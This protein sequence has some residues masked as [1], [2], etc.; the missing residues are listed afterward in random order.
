MKRKVLF[1]ALSSCLL[2]S[3]VLAKDWWEKKPYMQWSRKEVK[4]MLDNS[5]W[6]KIHT[7]TIMNRM[8]SGERTFQSLGS[9]DLER[10]KH[11]HFHIYFLTAKPVRMAIAQG[12]SLDSKRAL[13]KAGLERFVEQSDDQSIILTMTVSSVPKGASSLRGYWSTLS[14]LQTTNLAANT[15]LSTKTG[16]RVYLFRYEPP[17]K[18]GLGAKFFFPRKLADGS[19]FV[20]L[21]DKELRFETKLTL[22]HLS[23]ARN[24]GQ[25]LPREVSRTD[26]I[27]A[28]FRLKKMVFDGKLEI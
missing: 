3:F 16:K 22:R 7:V 21:E 1:F 19:P 20:T 13:D 6:G 2:S 9:G 12:F 14:N 18:D 4:K 11:N 28:Q 23:L 26:R 5:P 15:F 10:E 24:E 27:W 17:G 25:G 8:Y